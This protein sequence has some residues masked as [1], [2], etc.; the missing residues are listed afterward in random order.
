MIADRALAGDTHRNISDLLSG[1]IREHGAHK[2]ARPVAL[3]HLA[4][5]STEM[6][7]RVISLPGGRVACL[8]RDEC[9]ASTETCWNASAVIQKKR[10]SAQ[11]A[12]TPVPG[13]FQTAL[14]ERLNKRLAY[15]RSKRSFCITLVHAA[16]KSLTNLSWA[17][18][19]A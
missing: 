15:F 17:S 4:L 13:L 14:A 16:T 19:A 12:R 1:S 11:L 3:N 10:G 5:S 2:R 6:K 9:R 8:S 18:S 7:H